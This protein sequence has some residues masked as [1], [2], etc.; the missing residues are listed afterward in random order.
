MQGGRG[1]SEVH[2][3]VSRKNKGQ[4][5]GDWYRPGP[6]QAQ[7]GGGFGLEYGREQIEEYVGARGSG[8]S[9]VQGGQM[10]ATSVAAI[11][12][13]SVVKPPRAHAS[14]AGWGVWPRVR[15]GAG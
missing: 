8:V 3:A 14:A 7:Q 13:V 6:T 11:L 15:Q 1:A 9:E 5:L 12:Q 10:S 4:S 2:G